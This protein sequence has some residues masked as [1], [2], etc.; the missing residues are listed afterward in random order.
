MKKPKV[1][2]PTC[3]ELFAIGTALATHQRMKHTGN[4]AAPTNGNGH[5]NGNGAYLEV[6]LKDGV[7]LRIPTNP[8]GLQFASKVLAELQR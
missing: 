7:V 8:A 6:P 1:P 2:C 5:A 4:G 3:H